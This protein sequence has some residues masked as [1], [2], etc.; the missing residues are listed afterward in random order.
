MLLLVAVEVLGLLLALTRMAQEHPGRLANAVGTIF[1]IQAM[2]D[3]VVAMGSVVE[4]KQVVVVRLAR[5]K[6]TAQTFLV[7][8]DSHQVEQLVRLAV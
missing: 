6:G 1:Q 8:R 3:R 7:K 2:A 4:D 5:D